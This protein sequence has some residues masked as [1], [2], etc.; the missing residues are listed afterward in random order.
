VRNISSGRR[1]NASRW[2]DALEIPS[3]PLDRIPDHDRWR[4]RAFP[5]NQETAA[6]LPDPSGSPFLLVALALAILPTGVGVAPDGGP[7][8]APADTTGQAGLPE[9]ATPPPPDSIRVARELLGRMKTNPRG[10]YRRIRWFCADGTVHPPRPYPCADRG[11]GVQHGQLSEEARRLAAMGYHV[12]Q[13][14][15]E[16]EFEEFLDERNDHDRIRE[17]VLQRYLERADDGWIFRRARYYRGSRQAE[18]EAAAGRSLLERLL[19]DPDWARDHFLLAMEAT[20]AVPHGQGEDRLQRIR[21]LATRAAER[22]STF[23]RIRTKIHTTPDSGDIERVRSYLER[24]NGAAGPNQEGGDGRQAV[25]RELLEA[26]REYYRTDFAGRIAS[27]SGHPPFTSDGW[28]ERLR[29]L[30]RA[31]SGG[32]EEEPAGEATTSRLQQ[33]AGASARLRAEVQGSENGRHNLRRLDLNWILQRAIFR[34][35]TGVADPRRGGAGAVAAGDDEA[36]RPR[37]RADDRSTPHDLLRRYRALLAAAYGRGFYSRRSLQVMTETADSLLAR[38]RLAATRYH[39]RIRYLARA[40]DWVH[41]AVNRAFGLPVRRY[42]PVEPA[43]NDLPADLIRSSVALPLGRVADVLS[44][45]GRREVGLSHRIGDRSGVLPL[46]G[47]QPGVAVGILE[48][49]E[50]GEWRPE[51]LQADRIY[52]VPSDVRELPPVAGLLTPPGTSSLS[53]VQILARSLGIPTASAGPEAREEI[54]RLAGDSVLYAVTPGGRVL[55]ERLDALDATGRELAAAARPSRAG[56][57]PPPPEPPELEDRRLLRLE[58]LSVPGGDARVGPKALGLARLRRR[59][60][61]HVA[62]TLVLPFGLFREHLA[63][64]GTTAD[65]DL[66]EEIR[67][68]RDSVVRA[69]RSGAAL[70]ETWIRGRLAHFRQRILDTP[71]DPELVESLDERLVG[72]GLGV[73]GDAGVFVRSDTNVEDLPGFSGAGLNLTLPHRIRPESVRDGIRR[74][75]ASPFTW[76]AWRWRRRAFTRPVEVFVSVVLQRSVPVDASGV[77]VTSSLRPVEEPEGRTRAASRVAAAEGVGGA[78][79]GEATELLELGPGG[80]YVLLQP[81]HAPLRKFLDHEDGGLEWGPT[82]GSDRVLSE[83]RIGRLRELTDAVRDRFEPSRDRTGVALPWDMEFG[84]RGD[85]LWLFQIRPLAE[86]AAPAARSHLARLDERLARGGT[87]SVALDRPLPALPGA[88]TVSPTGD[89]P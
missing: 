21:I 28:P 57:L 27:F 41:G 79:E 55:L 65:G 1:C 33:L 32:R 44:D 40:P 75:W 14:L 34:E 22:D 89:R 46:R 52:V 47:G 64:A 53:H 23:S 82:T 16:M 13:L 4:V 29:R 83:T 10:P 18:D 88:P 56:R 80:R 86:G 15:V 7:P 72:W 69:G 78:V 30:E 9:Y 6:R 48:I 54:A 50:P 5:K 49:T 20:R 71:L 31:A 76:R 63:R 42:A 87:A 36:T 26:L 51:R 59:F 84:F 35:A 19:S 58:E 38:D 66:L 61:D 70:P 77:M 73:A 37:T 2:R 25:A 60:P 17:W 39:D 45:H 11:G 43:A 68:F 85:E 8:T 62:E 74:V 3:S 24:R 81:Y 12:G 67:S